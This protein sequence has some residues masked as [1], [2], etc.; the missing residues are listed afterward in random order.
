MSNIPE[1]QNRPPAGLGDVLAYLPACNDVQY[2]TVN[3]VAEFYVTRADGS[4]VVLYQGPPNQFWQTWL[5]SAGLCKV[6][7]ESVPITA[8]DSLLTL[9]QRPTVTNVTPPAAPPYGVI[10]LVL[11]AVVLVAIAV[12]SMRP[13]AAEQAFV[14]GGGQ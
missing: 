11:G 5:D 10:G 6:G 9:S 4:E 8:P 1:S 14:N 7:G 3:G 12:R 13:D 2:R